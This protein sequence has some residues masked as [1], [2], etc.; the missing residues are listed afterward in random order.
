MPAPSP[1]S[2]TVAQ[3]Q[4]ARSG[5]ETSMAASAGASASRSPASP[6]W[7]RLFFLACPSFY[8]RV[9]SAKATAPSNAAITIRDVLILI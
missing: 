5:S 7:A 9:G 8:L 4:K 2:D 6:N 1:G 3:S